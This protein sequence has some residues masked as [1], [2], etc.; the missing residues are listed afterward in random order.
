VTGGSVRAAT[1]AAT[2]ANHLLHRT[3]IQ[4]AA[5][6][7]ASYVSAPAPRSP[8]ALFESRFGGVDQHYSGHR[9]ARAAVTALAGLR[10]HVR[11]AARTLQTRWS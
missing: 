3:A 2:Y 9:I 11:R 8:L 5:G 4:D 6:C 10:Q 7:G 1:A